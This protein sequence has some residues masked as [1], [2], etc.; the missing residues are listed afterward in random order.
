MALLLSRSDFLKAREEHRAKSDHY[1][2]QTRM[3]VVP[4]VREFSRDSH[5]SRQ[6]HRRALRQ[7]SKRGINL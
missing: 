5:P 3:G 7:I 2:K 6:V 1:T 4:V